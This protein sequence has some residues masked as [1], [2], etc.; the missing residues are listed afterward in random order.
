[1]ELEFLD[2]YSKSYKQLHSSISL[3][4]IWDVCT[5]FK[6]RFSRYFNCLF[7]CNTMFT[8]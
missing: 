3:L 5:F 4:G 8:H 2:N 1:M 7:I 6:T